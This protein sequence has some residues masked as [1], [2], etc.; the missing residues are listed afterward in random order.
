MTDEQFLEHLRNLA[1][2]TYK[3][4]YDYRHIAMRWAAAA[5][6]WT[7]GG[8]LGLWMLLTGLVGLSAPWA[9]FGT[10]AVGL[11]CFSGL[12]YYQG[13]TNESHSLGNAALRRVD[14]ISR[15]LANS[16]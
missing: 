5:V 14:E 10:M 7:F 11:V 1:N 2:D 4:K 13:R 3:A 16:E 8:E 15:Q 9:M 6:V 12:A